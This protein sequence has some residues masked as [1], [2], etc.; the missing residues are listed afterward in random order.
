MHGKAWGLLAFL[1]IEAL[2]GLTVYV[3]AIGEQMNS[4][5]GA[6][7]S[8]LGMATFCMAL[9]AVP[10]LL[11]GVVV[12]GL[13]TRPPTGDDAATAPMARSPIGVTTESA[14]PSWMRKARSS[15]PMHQD[16]PRPSRSKGRVRATP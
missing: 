14:P 3:L 5:D 4:R 7:Y 9:T 13:V 15:S 16:Q 12:W 1:G 6:G 10:A 8:R 11:V 2:V